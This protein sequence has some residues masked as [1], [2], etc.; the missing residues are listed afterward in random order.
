MPRHKPLKM[1]DNVFISIGSNLGKRVS[2]IRRSIEG[3]GKTPLEISVAGKSSFY[4]TE[5]WGNQKQ[6]LF[7]NCVVEI[8]TILS[9]QALLARLKEIEAFLGRTTNERWGPRTI[10]LD[11]IFFGRSVV[12]EKDLMIPHPELHK[13][14]FVLKPLSELC[15]GFIHPLLGLSVEELLNGVEGKDGVRRL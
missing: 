5:P 7:I 13:R 1:Q 4:E 12:N 15:P 2:N 6:G 8:K 3:L 10:D 14:A 9:P 11:I